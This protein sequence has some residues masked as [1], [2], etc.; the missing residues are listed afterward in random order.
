[1]HGLLVIAL[2]LKYQN[3]GG[4]CLLAIGAMGSRAC[5]PGIPT[6][7]ACTA[8]TSAT[9]MPCVPS[10]LSNLV[11]NMV[12]EMDLQLTHIQFWK[13]QVDARLCLL[14]Y[15]PKI[16]SDGSTDVSWW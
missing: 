7:R 16:L 13:L 14:K 3:L 4:P 9:H 5:G 8:T 15:R 1:M 2:E 10:F 12:Q 11:S 6:L